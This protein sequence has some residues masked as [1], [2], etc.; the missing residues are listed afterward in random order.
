[1]AIG[2][3]ERWK[4]ENYRAKRASSLALAYEQESYRQKLS[5]A[6]K[7]DKHIYFGKSRPEHSNKLKEMWADPNGPFR[8]RKKQKDK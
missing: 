7:G 5:D 8:N 1:M 2:V 4:D 3:R 6:K